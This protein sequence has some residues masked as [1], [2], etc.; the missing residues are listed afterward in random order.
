M[1]V[2]VAV[3]RYTYTKIEIIKKWTLSKKGVSFEFMNE[4][5]IQKK[6]KKL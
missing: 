5:P 4:R 6:K 3:N 1:F 2:F